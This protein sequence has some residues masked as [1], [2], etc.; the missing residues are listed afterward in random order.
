MQAAG[1]FRHDGIILDVSKVN[2]MQAKSMEAG[3]PVMVLSAQ[4]QYIHTARNKAGEI[5]DGSES[6]VKMSTFVVAVT[7]EVDQASGTLEWK[8]AEIAMQNPQLYL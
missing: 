8:T 5:V 4:V 1:F 2:L 6:S 7:R 3:L